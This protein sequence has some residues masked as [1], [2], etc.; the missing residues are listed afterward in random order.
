MHLAFRK[1][2]VNLNGLSIAIRFYIL[3]FL[4]KLHFIYVRLAKSFAP[5]TCMRNEIMGSNKEI[6]V[7]RLYGIFTQSKK[8]NFIANWFTSVVGSSSS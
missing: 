5:Q 3:Q 2:S 6:T 8:I 1:G 4:Q 7:S